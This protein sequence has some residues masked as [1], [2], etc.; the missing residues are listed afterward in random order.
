MTLPGR[1]VVHRE[2]IPYHL[3]KAKLLRIK[4]NGREL[5]DEQ[6]IRLNRQDR[7]RRERR[8]P[9]LTGRER[10]CIAINRRRLSKNSFSA[11]IP[12]MLIRDGVIERALKSSMERKVK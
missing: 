9:I 10:N 12:Y 4:L 5:V 6:S 1:A 3:K 7:K 8:N 2:K 11:P